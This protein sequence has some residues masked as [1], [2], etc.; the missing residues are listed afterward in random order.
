MSDLNVVMPEEIEFFA[1]S[2]KKFFVQDVG[3]KNWMECHEIFLKL[4]QQANIEASSHRE[5]IVKEMLILHGKLPVIVHEAFCISVWR[6]KVLPRLIEIDP[7]PKATFMI[8]TVMFHEA[9]AISFLENM[10]FHENSC[11]ALGETSLDLIDYCAISVTQ[12]IGLI[13]S[14]YNDDN[15]ID[16]E[17]N[18]LKEI[19]RQKQDLGFKIGMKCLTI[20]R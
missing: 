15:K 12:L 13:N 3:H 20:L 6:T 11:E 9:I 10:L 16:I 18:A 5:E 8:Y 17:E 19:E 7:N 2:V 1:Q 4:N 14:G